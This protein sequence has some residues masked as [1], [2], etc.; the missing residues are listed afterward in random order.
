MTK[1]CLK[2]AIELNEKIDQMKD[3]PELKSFVTG[4]DS[5]FDII[6]LVLESTFLL[7]MN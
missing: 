5:L 3:I 6:S 4:R 2:K 1:K 7:L